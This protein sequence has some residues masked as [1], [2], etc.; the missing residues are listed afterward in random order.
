MASISSPYGLD[1]ISNQEGFSNRSLRIQN[2]IANGYATS[3]FKNSPVT[4]NPVTGTIQAVTTAGTTATATGP[5]QIFGVFQG[6]EYTPLG[7]RPV[8]SNFWPAGTSID[9]N[10]DFMVYV[11]PQFDS[12]LRFK[13]QANG[14]ITQAMLGAQFQLTN[15][16]GNTVT[17]LSQVQLA[18]SPI[19]AGQYGQVT[20]V[21]FFDN[22]GVYGSIGDAFTD[23]IVI[24]N[25]TQLGGASAASIG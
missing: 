4:I 17:G 24:V 6:C 3:I 15:F 8:V 11:T 13:V 1:P 16:V 21:E 18:A 12:T 9:P 25:A 22:T 23:C 2:G 14:P 5:T 19:A 10:Y 20:L 7:G